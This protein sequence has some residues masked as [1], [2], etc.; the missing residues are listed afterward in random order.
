M[1]ISPLAVGFGAE[2]EDVNL[3]D[4]V[5]DDVQRLQAAL[6]EHG[7]LVVR[8]QDLTPQEQVAASALF[9]ELETFYG[10]AAR[11]ELPEIFRVASRLAEGHTDVGRYWHSDGS[12]R[13][14]PTSISIWYSVAQA[15]E[16][17]ETLFTDQH[18]AYATLPE[19]LKAEIQN[20]ITLHRNGVEHPLVMPH[21]KT[22]AKG[23]YLNVGLTSEIQGLDA[24]DTFRIIDA[25]NNHLSRPGAVYAH[26][27]LPGDFV[28]SDSFRTAHQATPTSSQYR[29]V[30]D[31][32]TIKGRAAFWD[33]PDT[34]DKT[35]QE[36][37]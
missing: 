37:V 28:V 2:V 31:R 12:F 30:L 29:R 18:Q 21:P 23:I 3:N 33:T 1:K 32:T 34:L 8:R 7:L 25:L 35:R 9:G 24:T 11:A 17:G 4:I 26:Q 36:T 16:G 13:K 22:G 19:P 10:P 15:E 20:L 14:I 5:H 6:L 27:W